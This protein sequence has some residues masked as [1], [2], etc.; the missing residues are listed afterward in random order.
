MEIIGASNAQFR[1]FAMTQ[2]RHETEMN[3]F[4]SLFDAALE[5]AGQTGP[6]HEG[7]V[8]DRAALRDAAEMFESFFL[9]MMF[10]EMRRTSAHLNENAF[11][12]KSHAERIF[13]EMMDE[14]VAEDAARAGGIGIADMIYRQMTRHLN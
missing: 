12:P 9:N 14:Q 3:Q 10:R 13:T 7:T 1:D 8:L 2:N 4:R 5:N 11:I 6:D